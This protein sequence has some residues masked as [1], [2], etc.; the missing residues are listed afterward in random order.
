[1]D[2]S[3]NIDSINHW[4]NIPETNWTSSFFYSNT[5]Q[6]HTFI[7]DND[8][9]E[10]NY[11]NIQTEPNIN[12]ENYIEQENNEN[13]Q[14]ESYL[15]EHNE[16]IN[17]DDNPENN[18]PYNLLNTHPR[19]SNS[20][21]LSNIFPRRTRRRRISPLEDIVLNPLNSTLVN[22]TNDQDQEYNHQDQNLILNNNLSPFNLINNGTEFISNL[23]VE[24]SII[25]NLLENSFTTDKNK[26]KSV[27]NDPSGTVIKTVKFNSKTNINSSCP[28][29]QTDFEENQLVSI[30]PCNHCFTPEAISKWLN[31]QK[32][33]CP[34]CRE[35]FSSKEI[36]DESNISPQDSEN[37]PLLPETYFSNND[38]SNTIRS[39]LD[40]IYEQNEE[41][42][43][44]QVLLDSLHS[45]S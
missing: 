44:Q 42:Q 3:F 35:Q 30:L 18:H 16:I 7:S 45:H 5:L 21:N 12:I 24:N 31:E 25:R 1:M 43:L 15:F 34:V 41:T 32:A 36:S 6:G 4:S 37:T 40:I 8:E 26:Y 33:E 39:M 22:Y 17:L 10:N 14:P 23:D 28:I 27:L 38:L 11:N 29:F 19:S 9:T 2:I 20:S 13:I